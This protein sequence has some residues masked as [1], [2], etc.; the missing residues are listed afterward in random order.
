MMVSPVTTSVNSSICPLAFKQ[1]V[2]YSEYLSPQRSSCFGFYVS[3][4]R[5][6]SENVV[7][8][9]FTVS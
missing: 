7:P 1:T 5:A 3:T 4:P 2:V 8:V 6:T 9:F